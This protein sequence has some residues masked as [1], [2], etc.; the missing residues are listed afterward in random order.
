V[1]QART[2]PRRNRRRLLA[3]AAGLVGGLVYLNALNNPFV[4]D[5]D[6]SVIVNTSLRDIGAIRAI[7]LHDVT[8]PIANLS[9]AIDRRLWGA[10]P[11][12][13]H[14]TS[15]LL[16]MLNV[17]LLFG[18]AWRLAHDREDGAEPER[19]ANVRAE[20][21]ACGAAALFAVHPMMTEAVG[22]ISGRSEVLCA[23]WFLLALLC[24]RRWIRDKGAAWAIGTV[25]LWIVA[26]ATKETAAMFPFVLAAYD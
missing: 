2:T 20:L 11:T 16:H 14:V 23:T 6:R 26:L 4:Y 19:A 8:R 18:L 24:G 22:Y 17:V 15:V 9:Y 1:A 7:V 3:C 5:D 12:G 25:A 10:G 21:V 13:F